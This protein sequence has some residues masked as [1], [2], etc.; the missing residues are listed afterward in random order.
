ML[1]AFKQGDRCT[2]QVPDV[3][4][5]AVNLLVLHVTSVS[6]FDNLSPVPDPSTGI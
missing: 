2:E 1:S 5:F 4:N 3:S 6:V